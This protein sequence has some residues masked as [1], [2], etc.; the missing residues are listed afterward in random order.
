[1]AVAALVAFGFG[2]LKVFCALLIIDV[3]AHWSSVQ[4]FTKHSRWHFYIDL[5][6]AS[7]F[8]LSLLWGGFAAWRGLGARPLFV[9][10]MS[11]ASY[12]M[13]APAVERAGPAGWVLF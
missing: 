5:L 4:Q 1:M 7:A 2:L 8:G 11:L 13:A 9:A 6:I 12:R 3:L 10:G